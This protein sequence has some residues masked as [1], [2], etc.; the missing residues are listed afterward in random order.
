[1]TGKLDPKPNCSNVTKKTWE[2]LNNILQANFSCNIPERYHQATINVNDYDISE[3]ELI[4]ELSSKGFTFEKYQ[5]GTFLI[6]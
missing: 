6:K 2:D 1:M 4:E 5:D 3:N